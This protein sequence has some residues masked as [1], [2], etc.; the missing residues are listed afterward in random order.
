MTLRLLKGQCHLSY[1]FR[2]FLRIQNNPYQI[3]P[4]FANIFAIWHTVV[5]RKLIKQE[6]FCIFLVPGYALSLIFV[7]YS[8]SGVDKLILFVIVIV[9]I[10]QYTV[11]Y[12]NTWWYI[13]TCE[14]LREFIALSRLCISLS[15][16]CKLSS[17]FREFCQ[18]KSGT[19]QLWIKD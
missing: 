5:N 4:K 11:Q 3:F 9:Y 19:P 13:L 2:L 8:I 16:C 14:Y 12:S 17:I 10:A 7:K 6:D 15:N 1:D 18:E